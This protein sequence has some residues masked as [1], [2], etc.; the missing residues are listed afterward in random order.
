MIITILEMG[1]LHVGDMEWFYVMPSLCRGH[2]LV[3]PRRRRVEFMTVQLGL[4]DLLHACRREH[5]HFVDADE[6]NAYALKC[7]C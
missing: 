3:V 5:N 6:F 4:L 1:T 7:C 2:R